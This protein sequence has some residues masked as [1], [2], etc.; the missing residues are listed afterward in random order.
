M[1]VFVQDKSS[2]YKLLPLPGLKHSLLTCTPVCYT[3]TIPHIP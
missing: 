2:L 3:I 1:E